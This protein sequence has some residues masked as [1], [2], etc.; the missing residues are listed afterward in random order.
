VMAVSKRGLVIVGCGQTAG[1]PNVTIVNTANAGSTFTV[2]AVNVQFRNVR[3]LENPVLNTSP[4][5]V[6]TAAGLVLDHCRFECGANNFGSAVSLNAGAD[7]ASIRDTTFIST[8]QNTTVQPGAALVTTAAVQGLSLR[9]VEFSDGIAGF[10]GTYAADFSFGALTDLMGDS[11]SLLLG[12]SIRFGATTTGYILP[13]VTGGG[14][15]DI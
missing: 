1:V 11:V 4:G 3:I 12:A 8:A 10:E 6:V 2:S 13:T 15:I 9:G 7:R 14:A 5:M